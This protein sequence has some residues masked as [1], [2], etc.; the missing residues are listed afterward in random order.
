[1]VLRFYEQGGAGEPAAALA[2]AQRSFIAEGRAPSVWA[3][4]VVFG[5]DRPPGE[6]H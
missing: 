3:P 1:M 5:S 6:A 4:F 2:R